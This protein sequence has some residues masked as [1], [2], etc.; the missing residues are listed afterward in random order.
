[1]Q[2]GPGEEGCWGV[3]REKHGWK[4]GSDKASWGSLREDMEER[5]CAMSTVCSKA[6]PVKTV[7]LFGEA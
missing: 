2:P 1:M 3:F 7:D 4:H 6:T 5:V